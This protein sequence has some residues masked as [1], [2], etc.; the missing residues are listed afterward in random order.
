LKK[1]YWISVRQVRFLTWK[2]KGRGKLK[3][4]RQINIIGWPA[5]FEKISAAKIYK[6]SERRYPQADNC[7]KK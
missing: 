1:K 3:Q 6:T 4:N 2:D 7:E 5:Y